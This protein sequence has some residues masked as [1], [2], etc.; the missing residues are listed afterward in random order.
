VVTP[1]LEDPHPDFEEM[2]R[3]LRGRQQPE[4]VHLVELLV[5]DEV[6]RVITEQYLR[7]S[8][9]PETSEDRAAYARQLVDFYYRLGYDYAPIS[10]WPADWPNHPAVEWG[11]AEDT[12]GLSKGDRQWANESGALID[13]FDDLERFPWHEIKPDL[14]RL[15]F[16]A[17]YLPSGMKIV[18]MTSFF[19][20]VFENLLGYEG[21][22]DKLY[23]APDLVA[24]VF[25]RWGQKAYG[26]YESVVG[27]DVVGAIFHPDDMGFKTSTL[28]SPAHLREY[29]IPWLTRFASLAHA[30]GK[31]FWLHSC[32]NHYAAGTIRDLIQDVEI[33]A[34][35]SFEDVIL[36][37]TQFVDQFGNQVAALGGVDMDKLVRLP[38]EGLR[39]Y[40]REILNHCMPRGRYAFGS[41]NSIAN[42]VP[43]DN[44]LIMIE[45]ARAWSRASSA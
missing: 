45:E 10:H 28:I 15:R 44:Y 29:V 43:V 22:F 11:V 8:W 21:L 32:G 25:D 36:P 3:V 38:E 1:V 2:E 35:H 31:M 16:A 14:T 41:G 5:D 24:E 27:L 13:T 42:Y 37:V 40:V 12:A 39:S 19:E 34:L 23:E 18:V 17:D 6:M 9:V 4:R 26:F 30:Y 33:D 20:H 7:R